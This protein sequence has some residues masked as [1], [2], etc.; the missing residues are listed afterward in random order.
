MTERYVIDCDPGHDDAAALLY[1]AAHLDVAAVTTVFGNN[2][3]T[4]TT[5]NALAILELA[6]LDIPVYGGAV[7]S[8]SGKFVV[9]ADVHGATGLDGADLPTP[10]KEAEATDAADAL[11]ALASRHRGHLTVLALGPL[12]NVAVAIR[13]EPRLSGWIRSISLMGGSTTIGNVTPVAEFNIHCDPEAA[14][15]VFESTIPITMVGLNVT[16][17]VG[18][19]D[20]HIA[21]L[22]AKGGRIANVFADLFAFYLAR[23]REVFGLAAAS[24]HDP[25]A[26][27][28][29]VAPELIE[30]RDAHVAIELEGR[31][32]RGMTVCDLRAVSATGLQSVQRSAAPNARVAVAARGDEIVHH[33]LS[34]LVARD[35]ARN[36]GSTVH[37]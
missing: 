10:R 20:Q 8:L 28:P 24:L 21:F 13:R 14:A 22:R 12:T 6:G 36:A 3:L 4:R 29:F 33:V 11:I 34:A 15:V 2:A 25:C 27:I 32:T 26:V 18:I 37:D 1:A 19:G 16:R 17:Q 23:S 35:A 9:A 30:Y 31:H 5:R 7:G